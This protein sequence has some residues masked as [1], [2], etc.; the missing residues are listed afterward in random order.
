MKVRT[1]PLNSLDEI[2]KITQWSE[3]IK[4]L[5]DADR[6]DGLEMHIILLGS[7]P[8]LIITKTQCIKHGIND[9]W[10]WLQL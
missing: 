10:F 6:A 8:L 2:Q 9:R 5:W 4:G 7:S 3:T 1:G